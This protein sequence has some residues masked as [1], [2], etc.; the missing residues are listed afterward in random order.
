VNRE[1]RLLN[2]HAEVYVLAHDGDGQVRGITT[3]ERR[4]KQ[5]RDSLMRE[6]RQGMAACYHVI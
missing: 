1:S 2:R 4:A 6:E 3:N 5:V